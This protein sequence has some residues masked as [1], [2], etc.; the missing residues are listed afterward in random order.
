MRFVIP[1]ASGSASSPFSKELLDLFSLEIELLWIMMWEFA[2]RG[3]GWCPSLE[4][5]GK[6]GIFPVASF[7]RC[8]WELCGVTKENL[9]ETAW[10]FLFSRAFPS[11]NPAQLHPETACSMRSRN[12]WLQFLSCTRKK[13]KKIPKSLY[14]SWVF[15][16]SASSE[17]LLPRKSFPRED[18]G[19]GKVLFEF[20]GVEFLGINT[21]LALLISAFPGPSRRDKKGLRGSLLR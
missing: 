5:A 1:G 4:K 19:A 13:G 12:P 2:W 7:P 9:E 18:Q 20:P 15:S 8:S 21:N 17:L 3:S 6:K 11:L 16:L 14:F 10:E